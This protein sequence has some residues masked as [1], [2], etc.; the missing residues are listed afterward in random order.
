MDYKASSVSFSKKLSNSHSFAGASIYDGVFPAPSKF[1]GSNS[2]RVE[3]YSEI[4]GGAEASRGSSIP[5]LEIPELNERKI[6]V[7][8]RS[9]AL[10]YS[11]IFGGFGD[12]DF[13][14]R[15]EELVVEPNKRKKSEEARK[16]AE[17]LIFTEAAKNSSGSEGNLV[18]SGEASHQSLNSVKKFNMSYNK[19]NNGNSNGTNGTIHI[20]QLHAVRGYASVIDEVTPARKTEGDKPVVS[21]NISEGMVEGRKF[22][23]ATSDVLIGETGKQTSR[24]GV[25]FQNNS[26]WFRTQSMDKLFDKRKVGHGIHSSKVPSSERSMADANEGSPNANSPPYFDEEIDT[27]SVAATSAAALKKAIEEAQAKLKVAKELMEKKKAGLQNGVKM[28]FVD[29]LKPEETKE[30]KVAFVVNRSK[31]KK[32]RVLSEEVEVPLHVSAGTRKQMGAGA[33]QETANSVVQ[34]RVRRAVDEV[35]QKELLS[36]EDHKLEEAESSEAAEYFHE[37]DNTNENWPSTFD[38]D[39]PLNISGVAERQNSVGAR[40]GQVTDDF[41]LSQEV[42]QAKE[43]VG[44]LNSSQKDHRWEEGELTEADEQFYEVDNTDKNWATTLE[45]EEAHD[46]NRVMNSGDEDEQKEKK[47]AQEVFQK[48]QEGGQ[49]LKPSEEEDNLK[50]IEKKTNG[51]S[52]GE[53]EGSRLMSPVEAFDQ[54]ENE[55]Q[56][57]VEPLRQGETEERVQAFYEEGNYEKK[58]REL[59]EP[60]IGDKRLETRGME[61]IEDVKSQS[62]AC[63]WV[64]NEKKGE[65]AYRQEEHEKEQKDMHSGKGN[66]NNCTSKEETF[67][68]TVNELQ[69]WKEIANRLANVGE[70]EGNEKLVKGDASREEENEKQQEEIYQ[71][72][73]AGRIEAEIDLSVEDEMVK[74]TLEDPRNHG[75]DLGAADNL[76]KLDECDNLSE[77]QKSTLQTENGETVELSQEVPACE[78]SK[79][80]GEVDIALVEPSEQNGLESVKEKNDM[81]RRDVPE[82]NGFPHGLE[83]AEIRKPVVDTSDNTISDSNDTIN[84]GREFDELVH[85]ERLLAPESENIKKFKFSVDGEQV[86]YDSECSDEQRCVDDGIDVE[87]THSC[88][89]IEEKE[90]DVRQGQETKPRQSTEEHKENN[91]ETQITQGGEKIEKSRQE[92]RPSLTA[93]AFED[94][95]E[96][97]VGAEKIEKSHQETLPSLNAETGKENHQASVTVEE[98]EMDNNLRVKVE[99][100]KEHL[101]KIDEAKQRKRE[102]EKERIAVER[103]IREA[104]ERAFVEARERAAVERAASEARQRKM[105]ETRER[106]GKTSA[107]A[108]VKSIS[109]KASKEAKLKAERE[110]AAVERATAEARERAMEKALSNKAASQARKQA[111]NGTKQTSSTYNPQHKGPGSSSTSTYP[112]SSDVANGESVQRCKA[113]SERHQRITERA[114]KAL[115]E[116]NRRDLLAQKEQAERN[117]LAETLDIEVKRWS[118]GKEGN[119][120][121][122]LSTLQYILGPDSGWQS[123]PLT[124]VISA[125]AV[126]KAYRK[127]TL[128]VHPDKLQQRGASIQQKYTCEKVF[129]LLKDAWNK[130][131]VE[132]R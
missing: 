94:N 29:G 49:E 27:N 100:E 63:G 26:D 84:F 2:S 19:I 30:D 52:N 114:T 129:D 13:A 76:C 62:I 89:T 14:V 47:V 92:T 132:E 70:S 101:R 126:R 103:A 44:E 73:E 117:R 58:P 15:Y 46:T 11:N 35:L 37:V 124:D 48:P 104:R 78:E 96:A 3:D 119:L 18:S 21:N 131:N 55:A 33:G 54:K 4:F 105:A 56:Q 130:F 65:E 66:A 93:E 82:T 75:K 42:A 45:F 41:K 99:L 40:P 113:R 98:I 97:S 16:P 71:S 25:N 109:D 127:A 77:S 128:F 24:G 122:L 64:E 7:D 106:S 121:A 5:F 59:Q 110:R 81:G 68:E 10:D 67:V 1:R 22:K 86:E 61:D 32:T 85:I 111:D 38:A 118:S 23:R 120:R 9:S 88:D 95:H 90:E 102:R 107:E 28:N 79:S 8:V 125:P 12:S 123:I 116:K 112:N 39:F 87:T 17:R 60:T 74:A 51:S 50:E 83:L 43:L 69:L 115:E 6:S 31:K 36:R 80:I 91:E 108:N 34:E 57:R 72:L 20:A 53:K